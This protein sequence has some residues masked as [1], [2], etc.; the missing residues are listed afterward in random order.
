VALLWYAE[1]GLEAIGNG[2][3]QALI[4][5]VESVSALYPGN[6]CAY[7]GVKMNVLFHR[8]DRGFPTATIS[9]SVHNKI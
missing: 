4:S 2:L 9:I 8:R 3:F 5:I 7:M 1:T 6:N